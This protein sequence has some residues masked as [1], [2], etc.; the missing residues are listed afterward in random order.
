M[1]IAILL[2]SLVLVV[3]LVSLVIVR[4]DGPR[5]PGAQSEQCFRASDVSISAGLPALARLGL[6]PRAAYVATFRALS[7]RKPAGV[8]SA[9]EPTRGLVVFEATSAKREATELRFLAALAHA[10]GVSPQIETAARAHVEGHGTAFVRWNPAP[11]PHS[12]DRRIANACLG[13]VT[14]P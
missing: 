12:S 11:L 6:R 2:V 7:R 3:A 8:G 14:K 4:V 9:A 1:R 5:S 13:P 10:S